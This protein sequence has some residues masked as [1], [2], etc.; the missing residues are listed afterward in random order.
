MG[1]TQVFTQE[2]KYKN[3]L[4]ESLVNNLMSLV[5]WTPI[6]D[7]MKNTHIPYIKG[8]VVVVSLKR[9]KSSST[10]LMSKYLK[11]DKSRKSS[12][13]TLFASL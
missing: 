8:S 4:I 7:V 1:R 2:R 10:K 6:I 12:L 3:L 5:I 11:I 13:Y 9:I